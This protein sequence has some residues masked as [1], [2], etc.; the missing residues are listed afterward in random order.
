MS[1]TRISTATLDE[2]IAGSPVPVLVDVSAE[3][4]GP[5]KMLTPILAELADDFAGRLQLVEVDIDANPEVSARWDVMSFPTLLLFV[6][7]EL[8]WRTVGARGKGQLR[9]ELE[10]LLSP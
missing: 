7:G 1:D 2:V 10:R 4:C 6:D 9:L 8:T 5:C 3:W